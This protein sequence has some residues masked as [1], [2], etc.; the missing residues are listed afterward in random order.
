MVQVS[1]DHFVITV[2]TAPRRPAAMVCLA[3]EI[4]MDADPALSGVADRLSAVAP[5]EVVVDLADVTFASSTLL[6]F[7]ARVHVALAADTALV[8]CRPRRHTRRL[9]EMTSVGNL[10]TVRG[11]LPPSGYWMP[12]GTARPE[13]PPALG[14]ID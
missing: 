2:L 13:D 10:V 14:G 4:D 6:N 1:G 5:S 7:L 11:D 12:H 8:V 9:L 3:G